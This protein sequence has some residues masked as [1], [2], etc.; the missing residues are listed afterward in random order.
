M[1]K[2]L[3]LLFPLLFSAQ[4]HRFIYEYQ[5]KS[6]SLSENFR[7]ENMVLDINPEEVKFYLYDYAEN[8]SINKVRNYQ[9]SLWD[10]SV[11]ALSREKNSFNNTSFFNMN[12]LLKIETT[13]KMQWTLF[14]ETKN[15]GNYTLQKATTNFGGR[16][17][18]AWF[19]SEINLS[20]GPYKFRGLPGLIFEIA[21]DQN[22][23]KFKLLKS[24]KLK[25]TYSTNEFLESFAGQKAVLVSEKTLVKKQLDLFANPLKDFKEA[26]K[27]SNGAGK[28]S[29]MGT[30]VKSLDQ[31]QDLTQRTQES[32]RRDNNPLELDKALH[33]PK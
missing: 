2:F 20:E 29:V 15:E 24:Y 11:P 18:I 21:D 27:N 4:T 33:Y 31:F 28:F 14:A 16:N 12:V 5:F 10:D 13:D 6:D 32:M 26:F 17:W 25:T 8:D 22:N 7:K 1:K 30:E 19:N 23:F 3:F 9:N